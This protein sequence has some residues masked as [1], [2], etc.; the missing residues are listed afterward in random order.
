[1]DIS[2]EQIDN[3]ILTHLHYDHAGGTDLFPNAQF[4]VQESEYRFWTEDPVVQRAVFQQVSDQVIFER[5]KAL[6]EAGRVTLVRGDREV[7]PGITC[8]L[9]PGHTIGLQA[10]AVE[11]AKGTAILGSDCAHLFRNYEE[12]RPSILI[13][14]LPA[15]LASYDK[16]KA[17]VSDPSL[18]FPGHDMLM[19]KNYPEVAE[20]ITR[21]V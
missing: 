19:S 5:I 7:L 13:N 18:L 21:L 15:W 10:V 3:V 17:H 2:V 20:G 8:L 4:F 9:S 6:R 12:D 14:D 1:M 11:T 16:L